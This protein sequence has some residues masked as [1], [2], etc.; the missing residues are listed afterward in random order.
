MKA[1]VKINYRDMKGKSYDIIR[2]VNDIVT[3]RYVASTNEQILIDFTLSELEI[4]N[5]GN[6]VKVFRNQA[7]RYGEWL[8]YSSVNKGY[9][10]IYKMPSGKMFINL[11]KNPFDLNNYSTKIK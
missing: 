10:L 1:K 5:K 8:G 6:S 9:I 3:L 11:M 7:Y 4:L 2:I